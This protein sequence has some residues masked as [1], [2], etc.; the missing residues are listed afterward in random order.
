MNDYFDDDT[1]WYL[2]EDSASCKLEDMD[3]EMLLLREYTAL[4]GELAAS[5]DGKITKEYPIDFKDWKIIHGS[6]G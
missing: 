5:S 3:S 6:G 4:L 2:P 1:E